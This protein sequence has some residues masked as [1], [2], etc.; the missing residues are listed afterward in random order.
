MRMP[1]RW[2]VLRQQSLKAIDHHLK[3]CMFIVCVRR[4]CKIPRMVGSKLEEKATHFAGRTWWDDVGAFK[5]QIKA[6][7]PHNEPQ[8]STLV[9]H[10]SL[11]LFKANRGKRYAVFGK[12]INR[13]NSE[14]QWKEKA[15]GFIIELIFDL[16]M[17]E[18]TSAHFVVAYH[19]SV[20][21]VDMGSD[22]VFH[23]IALWFGA[24][25]IF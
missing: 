13:F 22:T 19:A 7:K 23:N 15:Q 4:K 6:L 3:I 1:F 20:Y 17:M 16:T 18:A 5:D 8:H 11:Y 25:K 12:Q 9:N 24:G 14:A 10:K 21:I 2:Y